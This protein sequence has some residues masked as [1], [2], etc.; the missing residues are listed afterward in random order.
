MPGTWNHIY[1][2]DKASHSLDRA[3]TSAHQN[4]LVRPCRLDENSERC[5]NLYPVSAVASGSD[6]GVPFLG[7]D[8][9]HA[10]PSC[11]PPQK[12]PSMSP[13]ERGMSS[14]AMLWVSGCRGSR[15]E[16][17][18]SHRSWLCVRPRS[19]HGCNRHESKYDPLHCVCLFSEDLL[20]VWAVLKWRLNCDISPSTKA[21]AI[22]CHVAIL[23]PI[24]ECT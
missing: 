23:H 21:V 9:A 3:A 7:S 15:I 11:L 10:R 8:N 19:R 13:A 14:Q 24:L 18:H 6:D 2:R 4:D 12:P 1:T 5:A 20:E 16:R 17:L 22:T